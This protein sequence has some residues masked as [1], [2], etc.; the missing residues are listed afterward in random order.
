MSD[1][2]NDSDDEGNL[3]I[4]LESPQH[5][6]PKQARHA[7][8]R[9]ACNSVLKRKRAV[10]KPTNKK[11][12]KKKNNVNAKDVKR[13]LQ[14]VLTYEDVLSFARQIINPYISQTSISSEEKL[15]RSKAK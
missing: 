3:T 7:R 11:S 1:S 12:V 2:S 15:T 6:K 13:L 5:A 10:N 8:P 9:R 4:V 14:E